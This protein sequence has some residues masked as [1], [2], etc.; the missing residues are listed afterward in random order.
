M[1]S[2][3]NYAIDFIKFI[4]VIFITNS[5]FVPLYQDVNPSF[6]TFGV[7][8][9]ALFFFA[10]GFTLSLGNSQQISFLAWYKKRISRI[11]PTF[12]VWTIL[13]NML[14][15]REITWE[16]MLFAH[17]YWFIQ[18]IM[19]V[20]V[21]MFA[22][23]K[24]GRQ[25]IMH[26]FLI[27]I[28]FTI[29]TI[30]LLD[31]TAQSIYHEFHWFCYISSMILGV[32]CGFNNSIKIKMGGVKTIVSFAS[33]FVIMSIGKGKQ[34]GLYY[35]QLFALVPLHLFLYYIYAWSNSWMNKVV[36]YKYVY[37]IL[38]C[39]A[40]LC[41]EIYVVQG[42][43]ITDKYNNVFPFNLIIVFVLIVGLAYF[44]RI[45]TAFFLQTL[46]KE[47]YNWWKVVSLK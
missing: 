17:G 21:F 2:Q 20:Y 26:A 37:D 30:C 9:N 36:K 22:L 38:F 8:G 35:T 31:K 39:I 25:Y 11:I 28:L 45:C 41:L 27:S 6:A 32:Y 15:G 47:P 44:L 24:Y 16:R 1:V 18:C 12:I 5:H 13:G 46:S 14:F 7:H 4:A 34:D 19:V 43:V 40:T 33:Y 23:L 10:S 3:R 29:L 42:M